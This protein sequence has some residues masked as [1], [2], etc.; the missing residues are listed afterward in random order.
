MEYRLKIGDDTRTFTI[1]AGD[2][3]RFGAS[4]GEE[5]YSVSCARVSSHHLSLDINGR[6]VNAFVIKDE[7]GKTVLID[8]TAYLVQD[9]DRLELASSGG[10]RRDESPGEVT[11]P[12]PAT[13]VAVRVAEGEPVK[14]N[15]P[16]IVVSA[17]KME[18]TLKA[19]YDGVVK[20]IN[21]VTGASV[22]PGSVLVDIE[23]SG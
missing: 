17:M 7:N 5:S 19:P 15:Q 22:M 1:D 12:I 20:K 13:V 6:R 16:V 8:G 11:S 23:K 21:V 3:G 10:N 14:K 18:M 4:C 2:E 9:A